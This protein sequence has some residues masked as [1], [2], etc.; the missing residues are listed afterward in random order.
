MAA[1]PDRFPGAREE[2]EVLFDSNAGDPTVEGALRYTGTDFKLKDSIGVFNPRPNAVGVLEI[3][4]RVQSLGS[5][6]FFPLLR[7]VYKG[8][9]LWSTPQSIKVIAS[10]TGASMTGDVRIFDLTNSLV[11]ATLSITNQTP[12]ILDLGAISNVPASEAVFELQAR[13]VAADSIHVTSL[14]LDFI[15]P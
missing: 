8:S 6:S 12:Q 5:A 3:T 1:T 13:V 11:V 15:A 2:D 14:I 10:T 9:V 4:P 7:F